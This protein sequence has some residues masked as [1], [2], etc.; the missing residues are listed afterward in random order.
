M[1]P[2][3]AAQLTP[4]PLGDG[5]YS[6]ARLPAEPSAREETPGVPALLPQWGPCFPRSPMNGQLRAV[7]TPRE[8]QT[9]AASESSLREQVANMTLLH[10]REHFGYRVGWIS[11]STQTSLWRG[12]VFTQKR[13]KCSETRAVAHQAPLS[14]GLSRQEYWSGMPFPPPGGRS[15]PGIEPS[16]P[17]LQADCLPLSHQGSPYISI[18]TCH[19]FSGI[20]SN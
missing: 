3:A 14:A 11:H 16:L 20:W 15:D 5:V 18:S 17:A 8:A 12:L 1:Y 10:S 4:L 6:E 2:K 7:L 19:L 9:A 13:S